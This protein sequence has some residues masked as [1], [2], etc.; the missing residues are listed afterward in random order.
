MHYAACF[1][2]NEKN[3]TFQDNDVIKNRLVLTAV[4]AEQINDL[5]AIVLPFREHTRSTTTV[6]TLKEC[7]TL[8]GNDKF[9]PFNFFCN[10]FKPVGDLFLKGN[11]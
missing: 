11:A 9:A 3:H 4:L 10:I 6:N 5:L 2:R 8:L 1:L 7:L